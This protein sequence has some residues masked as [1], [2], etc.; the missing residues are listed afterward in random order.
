MFQLPLCSDKLTGGI[1]I[2]SCLLTQVGQKDSLQDL[3]NDN[4]LGI[5]NAVSKA[6]QISILFCPDSFCQEFPGMMFIIKMFG[7]HRF[8]WDRLACT[9]A[10][11]GKQQSFF[12]VTSSLSNSHL[13]G[14]SPADWTDSGAALAAL[15]L[16]TRCGRASVSLQTNCKRSVSRT[17]PY[18][19]RSAR[20][21][22]CI[23][24][25]DAIDLDIEKH[26]KAVWGAKYKVD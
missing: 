24:R 5:V 10:I 14:S 26:R 9:G 18:G 13:D 3:R 8:L 20:R 7:S 21:C 6:T 4:R 11:H 1:L 16:F 2:C 22:F 15:Q 17:V 19:W 12:Q 23:W 25:K